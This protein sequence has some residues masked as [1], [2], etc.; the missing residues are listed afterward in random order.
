[1]VLIPDNIGWGTVPNLLTIIPCDVGH[2]SLPLFF[3]KFV[4][5]NLTFSKYFVLI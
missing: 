3:A 1:M 2:G 4:D 5:I